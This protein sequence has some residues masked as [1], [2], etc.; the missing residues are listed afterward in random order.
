[1][2]SPGK[3]LGRGLDALF[4]AGNA[5][6]ADQSVHVLPLDELEPNPDQ[7]R[8]D[9]DQARLEE[10]A[11]SIKS[12]GVMQPL[13]VRLNEGKYQIV[14]GERRWRAAKIAGLEEIPIL[15]REMTDAEVMTAALIENLQREDLNPVEEALALKKLRENLSITQ[16]DLAA[17]IGKSRSAIANSL[18]LLQLGELALEDLRAGRI[19]PGHARCLL[20]VDNLEARE[21]LRQVILLENLNVRECEAHVS[22]WK[23]HGAFNFEQCAQATPEMAE[24]KVRRK[25][26][27]NVMEMQK[28]LSRYF[29]CRVS[30]SGTVRKGKISINYASEDELKRLL[31]IIGFQ[32]CQ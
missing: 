32:Q 23:A 31:G 26:D 30:M 17:K 6:E 20:S 11:Q 24:R 19:S 18:R 8:Q 15:L 13:L 28:D 16:E 7:P 9:F 4:A 29:H 27:E 22:H 12:Q 14:A 3:G 5:D 25:K 2:G 1:M 10:L 21:R